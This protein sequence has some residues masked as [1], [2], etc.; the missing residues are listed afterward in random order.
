MTLPI[1]GSWEIDPY[2]I[3]KIVSGKKKWWKEKWQSAAQQIAIK[4]YTAKFL[5]NKALLEI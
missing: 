5:Q 4:A 3:K 1:I 2:K